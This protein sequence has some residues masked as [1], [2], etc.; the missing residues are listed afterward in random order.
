MDSQANLW[1]SIFLAVVLGI[2]SVALTLSIF[3]YVRSREATWDNRSKLS[4]LIAS[5]HNVSNFGTELFTM[6]G[7]GTGGITLNGS[8]AIENSN[9]IYL[10]SG[11]A[12]IVEVIG[13]S[14]NSGGGLSSFDS[15]IL[16]DYT[17]APGT[18]TKMETADTQTSPTLITL[19]SITGSDGITSEITSGRL[20]LRGTSANTSYQI[21]LRITGKKLL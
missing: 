10:T 9:T 4:R 13:F 8:S 20:E 6:F 19:N 21:G 18:I 16:V 11:S 5:N 2:L 12:Y 3:F 1:R 7:S 15:K 14:R 17:S